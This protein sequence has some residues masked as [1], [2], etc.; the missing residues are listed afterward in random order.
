MII[1][2]NSHVSV[3]SGG[4]QLRGQP[5]LP[6]AVHWVGALEIEHFYRDHPAAGKVRKLLASER[7]RLFLMMGNHDI[8][9]LCVLAGRHGREAALAHV[10]QR[11]R[12]VFSELS[13]DGKLVWLVGPQQADN[14]AIPGMG[15]QEILAIAREFVDKLGGWC[16]ANGIPVIDPVPGISGPDGRPERRWLQA[17]GLHLKAS[18]ARFYFDAVRERLG[19]ELETRHETNLAFEPLDEHESFCSL[20]LQG[21]DL[22][23][24]RRSGTVEDLR[25]RV[26]AFATARLEDRGIAFDLG[27]DTDFVDAGLFDSLDLVE[28]YAHATEVLGL[29]LDFDVSLRKLETLSKLCGYLEA[30]TAAI[31]PD[32][33]VLADFIQS[34]RGEADDSLT[35]E[36]DARIARMGAARAEMLLEAVTTAG[37]LGV[38]GMPLCWLALAYDELGRTA[39]A[40]HL[41]R[42]A[43]QPSLRFPVPEARARAIRTG[44]DIVGESGVVAVAS[45]AAA[46]LPDARARN[47]LAD[48]ADPALLERWLRVYLSSFS[49]VDD[50]ALHV[51]VDADEHKVAALGQWILDI[52][53]T[54][55]EAMADVVLHVGQPVG[56]QIQAADL[57]LGVG[58]IASLARSLGCP[59]R[60]V[61]TSLW[62][63]DSDESSS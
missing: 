44:R 54:A 17:D 22:P 34:M 36:A 46:V 35:R 63:T 25:G 39:E 10:L 1:V 8:F 57:V 27:L 2:G 40:G 19:L 48:D 38:Y 49:P 26:L 42:Q 32:E 62:F 6:V 30:R 55:A 58:P 51:F 43:V 41:L 53:G 56:A 15:P 45:G 11:Y 28:M 13:A 29:D 9:R 14:V 50:V 37:G 59:V 20:V 61:P 60:P 12:E 23:P 5:A 47:V 4:C 18:A 33:P 24:E 52:A 31:D 16:E 7:D 21:L 3:F